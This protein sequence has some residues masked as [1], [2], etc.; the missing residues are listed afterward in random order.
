MPLSK[1]DVKETRL[2][3]ASAA[4]FGAP[5]ANTTKATRLAAVNETINTQNAPVADNAAPSFFSRLTWV[6]YA[7]AGVA[8][9]C[10]LGLLAAVP[11]FMFGGSAKQKNQDVKATE[12][13]AVIETNEQKPEVVA[14]PPQ[15]SSQ[16]QQAE[17]QQT[18]QQAVNSQPAASAQIN[19]P[20]S[21][22]QTDVV[23]P[24]PPETGTLVPQPVDKTSAKQDKSREAV[25]QKPAAPPKTAAPAPKKPAAKKPSAECLLTG[26]C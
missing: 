18:A 2:N 13:P 9:L 24:L 5:A 3:A 14:A 17:Q 21:P 25:V 12:K 6:H 23:K 1:A 8:G 15:E 4:A 26:N 11:M 10:L 7:A 16:Q 20:L 22:Q 19:P